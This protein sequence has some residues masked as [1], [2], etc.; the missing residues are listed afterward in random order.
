[1][2][3]YLMNNHGK[4]AGIY[5]DLSNEEYHNDPAVSN[6]DIKKI[7]KSPLEYWT[8]SWMNK[9]RPKRNITPAMTLGSALHCFILERDKFFDEYV[10][11]PN[12]LEIDSEFYDIESKRNDFDQ[13]YQLPK[14][15]TAKTF[16]YTGSKQVI[17]QDDFCKI[18]D[19]SEYLGQLP[20]VNK[21]FT[22][23]NAEVSVFWE[24]EETGLMCKCR[25]DYLTKS[26][27]ADY[28]SIL[29]IDQIK[30]NIYSG[31]YHI[32]HAFYVEGIK[33]AAGCDHFDFFFV[34]QQKDSPYLVKNI[35]L[36]YDE[37]G[38][39]ISPVNLGQDLFRQALNVAKENF[40]QFGKDMWQQEPSDYR[41]TLY[42][43]CEDMPSLQYKYRY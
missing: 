10:V 30:S 31:D 6:S 3:G 21:I 15:K 2:E 29:S 24:D 9:N 22:N 42:L 35:Q 26:Y 1:M 25:P 16:R 27:I 13:N 40:E 32:Q 14:T 4:K 43:T 5:Y 17:K 8:H 28:K 12:K 39:N 18:K 23:G 37:T 41:K 33:K 19:M 36:A 20:I 34:F 7:L 11:L 38:E